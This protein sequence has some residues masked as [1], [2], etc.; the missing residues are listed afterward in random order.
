MM[1]SKHKHVFL[2]K[3]LYRKFAKEI[4]TI[5][6]TICELFFNIKTK[7]EETEIYAVTCEII[8]I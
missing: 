7:C 4:L 3:S 1:G 6:R 2:T 5:N 8:D